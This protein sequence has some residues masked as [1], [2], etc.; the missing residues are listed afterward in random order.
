M[1]CARSQ[2]ARLQED[3]S[4]PNTESAS[5]LT[6]QTQA[7]ADVSVDAAA[8]STLATPDF[9]SLSCRHTS[10]TEGVHG[11][12]PDA[13]R[14]ERHHHHRFSLRADPENDAAPSSIGALERR[15]DALPQ[16]LPATDSHSVRAPRATRSDEHP[17]RSE[18]KAFDLREQPL[19]IAWHE[20]SGSHQ[21]LGRRRQVQVA[22]ANA[23]LLQ[24]QDGICIGDRGGLLVR[25]R[26]GED[27]TCAPMSALASP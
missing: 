10:L 24:Y 11:A 12:L 27:T 4:D 3:V 22:E 7:K 25:K 16:A 13:N 21:R 19:E 26:H 6:F 9:S 5:R 20:A 18:I 2:V 17:T 8:T 1:S 14:H 15:P 23:S